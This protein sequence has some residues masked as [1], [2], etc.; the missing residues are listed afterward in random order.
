MRAY[1]LACKKPWCDE[2]GFFRAV[3][4]TFHFKVETGPQLD[5]LVGRF[6]ET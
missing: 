6:S 4:K 2:E 3:V 5:A 1:H